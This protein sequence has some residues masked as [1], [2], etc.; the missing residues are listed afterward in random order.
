MQK[1]FYKR[2]LSFLVFSFLFRF[3]FDLVSMCM[4]ILLLHF[5]CL[6][7]SDSSMCYKTWFESQVYWMN[8]FSE[9]DLHILCFFFS[10][11]FSISYSLFRSFFFSLSNSRNPFFAIATHWL[12]HI[13]PFTSEFMVIKKTL[14]IHLH[15]NGCFWGEIILYFIINVYYEHFEIIDSLIVKIWLSFLIFFR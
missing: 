12:W 10:P 9:I 7:L 15:C 5:D 3:E 2:P 11:L 13:D 4:C 14:K 8:T 6:L 1:I